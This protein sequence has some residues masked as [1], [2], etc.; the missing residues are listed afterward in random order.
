MISCSPAMKLYVGL[1]VVA[2]F[3]GSL[4]SAIP[5]D[6]AKRV[7][8]KPL[9]DEEHF[10]NGEHNPEFDHE[11]FLGEDEAKEFDELSPEESVDRLGIIITKIDKDGDGKVTEEELKNWIQ[12]V[13]KRYVLKDTEKQWEEQKADGTTLKWESYKDTTY[14]PVTEDLKD[15]TYN[16]K[17]MIERDERRW[18]RAD[19]DNDGLLSKEEFADFLHPEE[20]QHMRDIVVQETLEDIDKDKDG[21]I[22]LE[23]YIGDMWPNKG[24]EEEPDWVKKERQQFADFRDKNKDGK[25]DNDEVADWIIPPDY[26]QA[27]AEA[28]HLIYE[29]DENKDGVLTKEEILNKH[30]L[31]VGSQATDFGEAL[32]KHDEF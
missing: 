27:D 16:Y 14:G 22:S 12:Y 30:D 18:K 6:G 25:L 1:L 23:E 15:Q 5:R 4:S 3:M 21:H 32:T 20:V 28:K 19:K 13:Q 26:D 24:E 7:L 31:F 2:F 8:D 29:S 17:D 10:E 9:S 11:A